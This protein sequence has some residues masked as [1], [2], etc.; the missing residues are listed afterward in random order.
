[1][2]NPA[3]IY[4]GAVDANFSALSFLFLIP[5]A[6]VIYLDIKLVNWTILKDRGKPWALALSFILSLGA[7][8]WGLVSVFTDF[9]LALLFV[10]V[11]G[12][13]MFMFSVRSIATDKDDLKH[14]R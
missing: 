12:G 2:I 1:M 13:I 10:A 8:G 14:G 9:S 7:I 4:P 3:T 11:G 5:I 6:A